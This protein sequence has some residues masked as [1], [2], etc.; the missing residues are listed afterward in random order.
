MLSRVAEGDIDIVMI[1]NPNNPTGG[2]AERDLPHR[3]AQRA[4]TPSCSWTRRTS[5][6]ADTPCG[7][8]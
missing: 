6:S 4:P 2:L 7:P 5:S 3:P 8:T 1:A